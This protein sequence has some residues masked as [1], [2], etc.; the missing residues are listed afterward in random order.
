MKKIILTTLVALA[1]SSLAFGASDA[2]I[3]SFFKQ[4]IPANVNFEILS[5]K[6][7]GG[8]FEQVN[9]KISGKIEGREVTQTDTIFVNGDFFAPEL[10]SLKDGRSFKAQAEKEMAATGIKSVYQKEDPANIIAVGHDKNKPTEVMFTDPE[11]PFCRAEL[12]KIEQDLK[13]KNLK[14]ILTPVHGKSSLEKS[15]L[16]YKE[17]A[18][19]KTDS[20]KIKIM[21][22]YYDPKAKVPEG[23]VSEAQI[24]QMENL[25]QKYFAAGVR[26]TPFKL[27]EEN[28]K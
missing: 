13:V 28:L 21:R 5:K 9:I 10:I 22:K 3:E 11:C 17:V 6:D 20:E 18:K 14:M 2:Q 1:T 16:I 27:N 25:R 12:A 19:A 4:Q 15:F 8:G 26:S 7:L 24:D 23:S